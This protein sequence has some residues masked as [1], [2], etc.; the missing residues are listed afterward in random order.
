MNKLDNLLEK[1]NKVIPGRLFGLFSITAGIL[2]DIVAFIMYP[3]Y[4]FMRMTVSA[5]CVG[6][7][8]IFFNIGNIFSGIFALLF[9]NFLIRTFDEEQIIKKLKKTAII[10]ANIS[11]TCFIILGIFCGTNS[12]V[13]QIHGISAITSWGFGFCYITFY[14]VLILKDPKYTKNLAFFGFIVSVILGLLMILFFLHLL[15]VLRFLIVIL[16]PLEW[17]NTILVILWYFSVSTYM[18]YKKI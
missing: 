8:G 1:L 9:V 16:P 6:P 10:C 17:I 7:G 12:I 3:D 2:G 14:N 5:L 13:A 4:N 18:I 15:P 11:C